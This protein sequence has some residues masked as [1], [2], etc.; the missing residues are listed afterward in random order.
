[1]NWVVIGQVFAAAVAALGGAGIVQAVAQRRSAKATAVATLNAATL[2]W[3]TQLKGDAADVRLQAREARA[4]ASEARKEA[5]EA[6]RELAECR[7]SAIDTR[8]LVRD[9][10]DETADVADYMR[11]IINAIRDPTMSIDKLRELIATRDIPT[12][13]TV[14][15]PVDFTHEIPPPDEGPSTPTVDLRRRRRPGPRRPST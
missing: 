7:R 1:M 9:I 3:A 14:V 4:E 12:V 5:T 6:R 8:R 15:P 10:R 11:W 2:D 13:S